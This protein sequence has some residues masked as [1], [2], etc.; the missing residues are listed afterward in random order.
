MN[1]SMERRQPV[2]DF[3]GS[4]GSV[5]QQGPVKVLSICGG[6]MHRAKRFRILCPGC[7]LAQHVRKIDAA[8][9]KCQDKSTNLLH[10]PIL[11]E[12]GLSS[13]LHWFVD[14]FGKRTGIVVDLDLP[15]N[16]EIT[17]YRVVQ[18]CLTNIHRYSQSPVAA[19]RL[20]ESSCKIVLEVSD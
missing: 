4:K 1:P 17:I 9:I 11:D 13:A 12:V 10:P 3:F 5:G 19:I 7:C 18:E 16:L 8:E 14:G 15:R 2:R 20:S 6:G